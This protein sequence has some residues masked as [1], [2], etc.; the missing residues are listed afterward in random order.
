MHRV[1][2]FVTHNNN[3]FFQ[4]DC[5]IALECIGPSSPEFATYEATVSLPVPYRFHRFHGFWKLPLAVRF[6]E[7][8]RFR[9]TEEHTSDSTRCI[10]QFSGVK[11]S[12]WKNAW[13]RMTKGIPVMDASCVV[14]CGLFIVH[15]KPK[16]Q[17]YRVLNGCVQCFRSYHQRS[18]GLLQMNVASIPGSI[19]NWNR[20]K[21]NQAPQPTAWPCQKM[22]LKKRVS[23][24]KQV[25]L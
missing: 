2:F 23:T 12:L 9:V 25:I 20:L 4:V 16:P 7:I 15:D 10:C 5:K 13:H 18:K 17:Q 22:D 6:Y 19:Q 8:H 14:C 24:E 1:F 3:P 11:A 21:R